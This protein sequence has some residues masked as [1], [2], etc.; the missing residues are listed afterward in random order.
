MVT[1]TGFWLKILYSVFK[2]RPRDTPLQNGDVRVSCSD[3]R[4]LRRET[5]HF[6]VPQ[7]KP[8]RSSDAAAPPS[9]GAT[10][11]PYHGCQASS[12]GAAPE[13]TRSAPDGS[14]SGPSS[15]A[16]NAPRP[17]LLPGPAGRAP[18]PGGC[19]RR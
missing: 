13:L 12:N 18:S 15:G 8:P 16:S 6:L 19:S 17:G 10:L 1:R 5:P 9:E 2:E 11:Q 14:A 4:G 7:R 3:V